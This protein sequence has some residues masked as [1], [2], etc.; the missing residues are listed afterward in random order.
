MHR[1][2]VGSPAF[3]ADHLAILKRHPEFVRRYRI[4]FVEVT[5]PGTTE[6]FV[7]SFEIRNLIL[8]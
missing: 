7:K 2:G 3:H 1:R 6:F 5:T 8:T 4:R